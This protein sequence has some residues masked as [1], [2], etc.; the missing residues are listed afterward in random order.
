MSDRKEC[1]VCRRTTTT[2]QVGSFEYSDAL[3]E[4]RV[5]SNCDSQYTVEYALVD[6]ST[7]MSGREGER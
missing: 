7:D 6:V 3:D 2:E 5:C 1:P 4:V